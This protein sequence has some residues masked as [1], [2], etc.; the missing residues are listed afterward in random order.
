MPGMMMPGNPMMGNPNMMM[1]G[2]GG[3]VGVGG[4]VGGVVGGVGPGIVPGPVAPAVGRGRGK[5]TRRPRKN[6]ANQQNQQQQVGVQGGQ[7]VGGHMAGGVG[8]PQPNANMMQMQN[9]QLQQMQYAQAQQ[10]MAGQQ[11]SSHQGFGQQGQTGQQQWSYPQTPMGQQYGYG[12]TPQVNRFERPQASNSKQAISNMLRQRHPMNQ[13]MPSGA[14]AGSPAV[15]A[16]GPGGQYPAAMGPRQHMIRQQLRAGMTPNTMGMN[17][18]QGMMAGN[19]AINSGM[20]ANQMPG[21]NMGQMGVQ[22]MGNAGMQGQMMGQN[23]NI[24]QGLNPGMANQ[25]INNQGMGSQASNQVMAGQNISGAQQAM[26][27]N[28]Q[29]GNMPQGMNQN[30]PGYTGQPTN[31]QAMMGGFQGQQQFTNQQNT[32]MMNQQQRN[33]HAEYMA[34]RVNRGSYMQQQQ[35]PNVTMNTMGGPAPPY[36]RGGQPGSQNQVPQF[37]QQMNP[38]QSQRMRQQML[39]LQ[40]QQQQQ[41]Q[42]QVQQ[43]AMTNTQQQGSPALV[44]QLQRQLNQPQQAMMN[45]YSH[46]PPPY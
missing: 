20:S 14:G 24:G 23:A 37:P 21:Q 39:A 42:Q 18:N 35:A 19:Q 26:F 41:A 34:Q 4:M 5:G 9:A 1:M 33:A 6:K 12:P 44:A 10:G 36:P 30:Y 15:G 31:Q 8:Q 13:F 38:Q 16:G 27:Q 29:Y 46:Q 7:A 28:Q 43:Q 22:G 32:A 17:A 11:Q 45:Q 25:N 3:G 40:Q 2:V